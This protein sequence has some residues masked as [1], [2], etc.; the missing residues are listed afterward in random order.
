MSID[1][2][3]TLRG[4]V[5]GTSDGAADQ[6]MFLPGRSVEKAT[7]VL[8]VEE[9]GLGYQPWRM[10]EDLAPPG[11]D[12]AV[13]MLDGEAGTVRFGDGVR[14]RIPE[15]GRRVRVAQ[16]RSG[17]GAAGN[18]PAGLADRHLRNPAGRIALAQAEGPPADAGLGRGGRRDA[19]RGG[20]P[21]PGHPQTR[22]T[23]GDEPGLQATSPPRRRECGWEGS[24]SFPG[25]SRISGG[26]AFP[27][28]SR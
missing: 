27:G 13:F 22:P 16:M 15:R 28:W 11:R 18:L 7:F 2:R 19:G 1:Q 6:E 23:G 8:Q 4:R 25:S 5:A 24:S 3:Q 9:T 26:S 17:G 20:T 12:D 10:V 21:D 14:G